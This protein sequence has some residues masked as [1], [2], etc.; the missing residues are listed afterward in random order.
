MDYASEKSITPLSS[1]IK[2]SAGISTPPRGAA[3]VKAFSTR[4]KARILALQALYEIDSAQRDSQAVLSTERPQL[5]PTAKSRS[6]ARKVVQ[7]VV[8][9][10]PEIDALIALHAP[11]WPVDQ[12]AN[13]D[14]NI[15][16][17]AIFE[18]ID[19]SETPPKVVINEAI[20]LAKVFGSEN[21]PKFVNGVLGAVVESEHIE[22]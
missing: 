14:R 21:S 2:K 22:V 10:R 9:K 7:G 8:E 17:I 11:D 4:H 3:V 5:T 1:I 16:R 12:I 20:E 19:V 6:F 15:L 18:L 13:V